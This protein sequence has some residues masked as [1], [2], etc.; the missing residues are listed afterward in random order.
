MGVCVGVCV[1]W[2]V[3]AGVCVCVLVCVL[4]LMLVCVCGG[5]CVCVCVDAVLV[6][7]IGFFVS[8]RIHLS[9]INNAPWE[10][11]TPDLEVNSLTL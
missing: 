9:W 7:E 11:R 4:V 1:C 3:C 8:A 10:A 2:C 6:R 5:V